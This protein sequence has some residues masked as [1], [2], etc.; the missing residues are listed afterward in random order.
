VVGS[1]GA[2]GP[3]QVGPTGPAGPAGATGA[4]GATGRTGAQ[5][6]TQV[7]GVTGPTG[8][9]GATGP[10]GPIGQTGAQGPGGPGG[11]WTPFRDFW[12]DYNRSDLQ[13][14][15]SGKAS[16][17]A[18]YLRQNPGQQVGIDG[19]I[20]PNNMD[21]SNRRVSTVRNALLQAGVPSYKIQTG[22]FGNPALQ[23]DR[24]VEVL[25]SSR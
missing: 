23:R 24:R 8:R 21:L 20:D 19:S 4:Q 5:G 6:N 12:F 1:T 22:T 3:T 17:I 16:D 7:A 25:V 15:D 9:T 11:S 2:Q 14:S 10:Q 18:N 13:S